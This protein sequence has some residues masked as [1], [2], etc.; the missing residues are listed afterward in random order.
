MHSYI[1]YCKPVILHNFDSVTTMNLVSIILVKNFQTLHA[2]VV[3]GMNFNLVLV[4]VS[5]HRY[6]CLAFGKF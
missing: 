4:Q 1:I 5:G 6:S 3:A 2:G